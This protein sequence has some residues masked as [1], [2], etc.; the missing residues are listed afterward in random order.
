MS[1]SIDVR[2]DDTND[3]QVALAGD[4]DL[5]VVDDVNAVIASAV[6]GAGGRT[7]AVDLATVTFLDSS[8]IG[9]LIRGRHLAD[10]AGIGF[11]VVNAHG[12]IRRV[13]EISGV[14]PLLTDGGMQVVQ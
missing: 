9:C 7:V 1:L 4:I 3:V 11:R 2:A 10:T 14:W 5:A 8:G 12:R 6:S 13:L